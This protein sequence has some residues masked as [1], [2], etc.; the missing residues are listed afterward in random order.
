MILETYQT[1]IIVAV[2][3]Y[4]MVSDC[5]SGNTNPILNDDEIEKYLDSIKG[6]ENPENDELNKGDNGYDHSFGGGEGKS[7][8]NGDVVIFTG[9]R[10]LTDSSYNEI[11]NILKEM[12]D[13]GR[14]IDY[15]A[16][17]N[18]RGADKLVEKACK[19]LGI[20]TQKYDA[21][22]NSYGRKAGP[23]RNSS[24]IA[25]VVSDN[26]NKG[27]SRS[28]SM[29]RIKGIAIFNDK[30]SPGTSDA[31]RR[32]I[33]S[34]ISGNVKGL[35]KSDYNSMVS[36]WKTTDEKDSEEDPDT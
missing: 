15:V 8:D 10:D 5:P 17:G 7:N 33:K 34:G 32:M 16:H 19:E 27:T 3:E 31:L 26:I 30:V 4:L 6:S 1:R 14:G 29:S 22:W 2:R 11:Y 25:D 13:T 36:K 21:K 28:D 24:M 23:I 20:E 18:A 12:R 9:S 35:S